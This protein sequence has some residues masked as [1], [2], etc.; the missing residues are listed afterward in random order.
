MDG[1]LASWNGFPLPLVEIV[2]R[3]WVAVFDRPKLF[4]GCLN[5]LGLKPPI[6]EDMKPNQQGGKSPTYPE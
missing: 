5:A 1:F 6:R 4:V 2:A 3:G